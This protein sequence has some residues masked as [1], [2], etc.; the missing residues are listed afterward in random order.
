[1]PTDHGFFQHWNLRSRNDMQIPSNT[2]PLFF[3][4]PPPIVW[5]PRYNFSIKNAGTW[6]N[7]AVPFWI[8]L[9]LVAVPTGLLFY[10]DRKPKPGC[11]AKCRYD[12]AGLSGDTCPE[13]GTR[14]ATIESHHTQRH[15]DG[16]GNGVGVGGN[17]VD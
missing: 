11:C 2:L 15:R 16:G 6:R 17:G 8:P 10:R 12:L 14:T 7:V 13:C 1:M 9:V 5:L 3:Q 4:K